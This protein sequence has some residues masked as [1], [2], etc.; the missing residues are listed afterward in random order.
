[1]GKLR[2]NLA[3]AA[4][5]AA[6]GTAAVL[7]LPATAQAAPA[8]PCSAQAAACIDLSANTS[9]LM[10]NGVVTYGGVPITSGKPGYETPPG[11]FQVTYKDID[12]WS[13]AYDAPMPYSVFFTTSGIAFHEGSLGDQSHGCIH[14]SNAAAQTYFSDLQPGD[15]VEVVP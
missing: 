9:W 14:L 15:V 8:A 5:S 13:R 7:A 12:H 4:G 2:R 10:D 6:L 11:T 1:M 3:M